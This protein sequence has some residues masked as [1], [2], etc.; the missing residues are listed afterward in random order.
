VVAG[1]NYGSSSTLEATANDLSRVYAGTVDGALE[2][3]LQG[4]HAMARIEVQAGEHF[5]RALRQM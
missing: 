5:A 4:D 2:Q 1:Q 3:L